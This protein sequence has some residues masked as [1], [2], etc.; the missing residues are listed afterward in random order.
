MFFKLI[1]KVYDARVCNA[2]ATTDNEQKSNTV[3]IWNVNS[4]TELSNI[5]YAQKLPPAPK[6]SVTSA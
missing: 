4:C 5:P 2:L 3:L 1:N 6:Y